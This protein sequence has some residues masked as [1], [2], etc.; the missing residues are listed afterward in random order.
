[1]RLAT[2]ET[3]RNLDAAIAASRGLGDRNLELGRE[4][5]PTG[6]PSSD[7]HA[8]AFTSARGKTQQVSV[9]LADAD[10]SDSEGSLPEIDSGLDDDD[11]EDNDPESPQ[12]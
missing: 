3:P 7:S 1:V 4:Q 8:Q 6:V 5:G 12:N 10:T 11:D 2:S 9:F